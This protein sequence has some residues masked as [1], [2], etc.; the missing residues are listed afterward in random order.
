MVDTIVKGVVFGVL[1]YVWFYVGTMVPG[2]ADGAYTVT[3]NMGPIPSY[4]LP[5][6]GYWFFSILAFSMARGK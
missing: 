3:T 5:G 6:F 2:L 4:S 1:V